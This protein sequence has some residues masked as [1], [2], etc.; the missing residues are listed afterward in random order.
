MWFQCST[1]ESGKEKIFGIFFFPKEVKN[2]IPIILTHGLADN[3]NQ[4]P[5]PQ[6]TRELIRNGFVV[7]R[8]DFRGCGSSG[9]NQ[10]DYCI[11]SQIEDLAKVIEFVKQKTGSKKVGIISK[12]ISCVASFIVASKRNDV[13]FLIALGAPLNLEKY[14]KEE[15]IK[16][17]REKGYIF[18]K[19]FKYGHKLAKEMKEFREK[20]KEALRRISIPVLLIRGEK[21]ESVS[22]DEAEKIFSLLA[23]ENKK[24]IEIKNADHSFKKEEKNLGDLL[25]SILSFIL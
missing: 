3:L 25:T 10:E 9:G 18:Y 15:E 12:S 13:A 23:S 19:G 5:L 22:L 20:Y 8:F 2:K 14:W 4:Y 11:S 17:A 24:L 1:I 7:F 21:D 16:I 6:I